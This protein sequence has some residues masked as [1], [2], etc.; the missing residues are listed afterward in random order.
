MWQ[1]WQQLGLGVFIFPYSGPKMQQVEAADVRQWS[2]FN[3]INSRR[4]GDFPSRLSW[5][6]QENLI[7]GGGQTA[8]KV[9]TQWSRVKLNFFVGRISIELALKAPVISVG[10]DVQRTPTPRYIRCQESYHHQKSRVLP[11]S[12]ST[13]L[14]LCCCWEEA[15]K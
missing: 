7:N 13:P 1:N 15:G 9:L 8:I 12:Q 5:R 14:T 6:H 4:T 11:P 3:L 10:L 2:F